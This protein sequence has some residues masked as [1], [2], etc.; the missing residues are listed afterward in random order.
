MRVDST[1]RP[2]IITFT[3]TG[4]SYPLSSAEIQTLLDEYPLAR[5]PKANR[6]DLRADDGHTCIIRPATLGGG[7]AFE[8]YGDGPSQG[9]QRAAWDVTA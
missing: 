2:Y 3:A 4:T 5:K 8:F 1:A 9:Q 6:V 7:P